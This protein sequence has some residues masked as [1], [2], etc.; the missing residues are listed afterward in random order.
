MDHLEKWLNAVNNNRIEVQ[1]TLQTV[2]FKLISRTTNDGL[3]RSDS[4][5]L[6]EGCKAFTELKSRI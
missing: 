5:R 4:V 6:A 1:D 2:N 3:A